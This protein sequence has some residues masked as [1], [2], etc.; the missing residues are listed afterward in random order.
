MGNVLE[1][2]TLWIEGEAQLFNKPLGQPSSLHNLVG[3]P[4]SALGRDESY[5]NCPPGF[6]FAIV[7]GLF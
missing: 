6:L 2:H 3:S 1:P 7:T 4:T 5:L